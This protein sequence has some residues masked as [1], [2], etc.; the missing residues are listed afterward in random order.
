MDP[1]D[2]ARA[3][4][5]IP[6]AF[7][8]KLKDFWDDSH[9]VS[10]HQQQ[11]SEGSS[12]SDSSHASLYFQK[13]FRNI[14]RIRPPRSHTRDGV[15]IAHFSALPAPTR[16]SQQSTASTSEELMEGSG[17]NSRGNSHSLQ[18]QQR[19]LELTLSNSGHAERDGA[20]ASGMAQDGHMEEYADEADL[21][22]VGNV[23]IGSSAQGPSRFA[24]V[25]PPLPV[26]QI[27]S[28][29]ETIHFDDKDEWFYI[30]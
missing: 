25:T 12:A 16:S 26:G 17:N 11:Q 20:S 22:E 21:R 28:P 3:Q 10:Q 30:G 2:D 4:V 18:Q 8:R 14:P 9:R 23:V 19:N 29:K 13:E 5:V 24:S 27:I 1:K 6:E 7:F 15:R